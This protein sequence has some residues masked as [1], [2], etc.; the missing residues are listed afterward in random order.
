M[1]AGGSTSRRMNSRRPIAQQIHIGETNEKESM[2]TSTRRKRKTKVAKPAAPEGQ[3]IAPQIPRSVSI[4]A[5]GSFEDRSPR[6]SKLMAL[7]SK[8]KPEEVSVPHKPRRQPKAQKPISHFK[9]FSTP[10]GEM[11]LKK[12]PRW[13]PSS[14]TLP[15]HTLTFFRMFQCVFIPRDYDEPSLQRWILDS[16][17][18]KERATKLEQFKKAKAAS[19]WICFDL[20]GQMLFGRDWIK[21]PDTIPDE[22]FLKRAVAAM[23]TGTAIPS[24]DGREQDPEFVKRLFREFKNRRARDNKFRF[25]GHLID[26]ALCWTHPDVPLWMMNNEAG[27]KMVGMLYGDLSKVQVE[28]YAQIIKRAKLPR[29]GGFPIM[30]ANFDRNKKFIGYRFR[31]D[32]DAVIKALQKL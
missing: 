24:W 28:N 21:N 22:F 3:E 23:E 7:F 6:L 1:G 16:L 25:P 27:S 14:S 32:I 18:V 17:D 20:I 13:V 15:A 12:I 30:D 26:V 29:F 10:E 9:C 11:L 8:P 5:A 31:A 4:P 19:T 2:K